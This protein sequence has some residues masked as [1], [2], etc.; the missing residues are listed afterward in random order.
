MKAAGFDVN[1]PS[2]LIYLPKKTGIHPTRSVHDGWN[3]GHAD[4][5]VDIKQKLN[6]IH[7]IGDIEGWSKQQY[8]D[9]IEDLRG[10]TRKGLRE[11]KIK[12]H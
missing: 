10:D 11:G 7:Q 4:Y 9:A 5:N 3:K 2:N 1:K 6:E 8:S 12:C